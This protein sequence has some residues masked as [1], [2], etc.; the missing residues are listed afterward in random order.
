MKK[1][2]ILCAVVLAGCASKPMVVTMMP[3][4]SGE[5]YAG[6]FTGSSNG[7]GQLSIDMGSVSCSGPAARV[8]S[9]EKRTVHMV[10]NFNGGQ[11][12]IM[13]SNA[14]GDVSVKAILHCTDGTGMRCDMVGRDRSGGGTCTNDAG[15]IFDLIVTDK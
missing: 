3:R 15:R 8:S 7:A 4:S 2:L 14:D 11:P 10:P 1:V 6:Q 12:I 5:T 9:D 13:A